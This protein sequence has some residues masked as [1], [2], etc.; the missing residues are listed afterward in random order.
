MNYSGDW[1]YAFLSPAKKSSR[2]MTYGQE[3]VAVGGLA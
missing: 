1:L 3:Y 2:V